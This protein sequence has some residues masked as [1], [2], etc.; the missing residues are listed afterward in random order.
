MGNI[1]DIYVS[2]TCICH[3]FIDCIIYFAAIPNIQCSI[4]TRKTPL[5]QNKNHQGKI[6]TSMLVSLKIYNSFISDVYID[7]TVKMICQLH[8]LHL[9][10]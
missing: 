8:H 5:I 6:P 9:E 10:K 2:I 4:F 3:K 7:N 1:S